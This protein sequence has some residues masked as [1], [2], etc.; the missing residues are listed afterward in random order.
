MEA[1]NIIFVSSVNED[2]LKDGIEILFNRTGD[3]GLT[4]LLQEIKH[5]LS[6]AQ[7]LIND[8]I[9]LCIRV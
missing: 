1:N 8:R 2:D 7:H 4:E 9:S 6:Q 5:G 3:E